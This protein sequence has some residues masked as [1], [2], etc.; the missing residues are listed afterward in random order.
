MIAVAGAND[1][2]E[3]TKMDIRSQKHE[4]IKE[5]YGRV[6]GGTHDIKTSDCCCD[7]NSTP[8]NVRDI[9]REIEPEIVDRFYGCGSP[10]PPLLEGLTILDLGCGTGRDV[11]I[12]SKLAG[13]T[14]R[15]IGVDMTEE[16]IEVARRHAGRM[17]EKFGH[18]EKNVDFRLGYIEDLAAAGLEDE[19]VDVVVSNCVIN[20]SPDKEAVFREIFRVLK[21]GGE[22]CFS[23]VVAGRRLP[24]HLM[25][26]ST[27]HAECLSGAMYMEDFRRLLTRLGYPDHRILSK[28]PIGL[29]SPEIEEKI[30]MTDFYSLTVRAFK[31]DDLEDICED[32]GQVAVYKGTAPGNP[33]FFDLDDHHRF[34]SGKP[35]LVC[36]NTASMLT[37]TRFSS[38][39]D[40]RGGRDVHYGPFDCSSGSEGV[41]DSDCGG[42]CC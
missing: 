21:P 27:L 28:A 17:A 7:E 38:H 24:A 19:S 5:Y 42:A 33:H 12:L 31:L 40:V 4:E 41:E 11:Y 6:L 8:P 15:V 29:D 2:K 39:F 26:D 25:D 36:G 32:Y 13:E 35:M 16:Q 3:K 18:A 1:S 22:L 9:I 10:I 23:D 30:G 20:L 37:Q 14:G 34:V